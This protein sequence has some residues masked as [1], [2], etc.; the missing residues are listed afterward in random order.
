MYNSIIVGPY[1][2]TISISNKQIRI[3]CYFNEI[4]FRWIY[5]TGIFQ[6]IFQVIY[7]LAR[8]NKRI[9]IVGNVSINDRT[10]L[11]QFIIADKIKQCTQKVYLLMGIVF[12]IKFK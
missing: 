11:N 3:V 5:Q 12:V 8:F 2:K 1:D 9:Y 4:N 10:D 7:L 6:I